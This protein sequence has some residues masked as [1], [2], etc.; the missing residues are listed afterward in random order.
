MGLPRQS[1]VAPLDCTGGWF[2]YQNWRGVGVD[3]LLARAN[4]D[5]SAA[6][7]T[8]ESVTG[9]KRRFSLAEASTFMLALGN[10]PGQSI[11]EDAPLAPLAHGHGYP[12]RLIAPGR[13]GME[14]V[15][16]VAVIR[17]NTAG[18]WAQSP[19]PLQ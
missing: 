6:S 17:V 7:V 2:S 4:V 10:A 3:K 13:R 9:Y 5:P 16:W 15:K 18:P 1:V 8:F 12:A 11:N 19:L 14:W